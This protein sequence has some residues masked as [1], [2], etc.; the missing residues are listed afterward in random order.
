MVSVIEPSTPNAI[1]VQRFVIM[2]KRS[3]ILGSFQVVSIPEQV[4]VYCQ[5]LRMLAVL[6]VF[7]LARIGVAERDLVPVLISVY[8]KLPDVFDKHGLLFP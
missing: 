7:E 8:N 4:E 5:S 2:P 1:R 3:V 6:C